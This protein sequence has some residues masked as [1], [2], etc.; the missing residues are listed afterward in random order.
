LNLKKLIKAPR[1]PGKWIPLGVF[2][3][4]NRYCSR[5]II[6]EMHASSCPISNITDF[7][8]P[9]NDSRVVIG[10]LSCNGIEGLRSSE[11]EQESVV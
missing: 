2:I 5:K 1:G 7:L 8:P 11:N 4:K 9:T 3:M 6:E 10:K